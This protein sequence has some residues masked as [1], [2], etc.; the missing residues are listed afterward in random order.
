MRR[1]HIKGD[2]SLWPSPPG[3]QWSS[4]G[5][6]ADSVVDGQV[7]SGSQQQ[8]LSRNDT[9]GSWNGSNWNMV[10]VGTQGAPARASP[11]RLH[12]R[13]PD[14]GRAGEAVPDRS[15]TT[16]AT[17]SSCPRFAATAP[18]RRGPPGG[19][20]D[21][22]SR[23]PRF[24]VAKPGDSAAAINEALA[25]GRHLLLTPGVYALSSPL[26]RHPPR[27]RRAR[28]GLG[29][30]AGHAR[31][32]AHRGRRRRRRLHRRRAARGRLGPARP[33]CC[34]SATVA[35]GSGTPTTPPC[36]STSTP[37]S[38]APSRAVPPSAS[39]S[40]ATT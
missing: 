32:L 19:P 9:F 17:A 38:A 14:P 40:T 21:T 1:A 33:F 28:L 15:P 8:W 11:A 27:H 2:M 7:Q 29:H 3:N 23:C 20:R 39:S 35:A 26:P 13:R 25:R 5:F 10:F 22:A 4:G 34:A 12:H 6:L 31:Q 36:S 18:G 24:H 16:A 37:A 30:P